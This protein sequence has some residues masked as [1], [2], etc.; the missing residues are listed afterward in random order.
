M[1]FDEAGD[2]LRGIVAT[3]RETIDLFRDHLEAMARITCHRGL[4][5]GIQGEDACSISD[6][7]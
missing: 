3:L 6:R 2:M 4:D 5:R 7:R 1:H